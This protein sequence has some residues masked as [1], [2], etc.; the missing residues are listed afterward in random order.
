MATTPE[1]YLAAQDALIISQGECDAC[2]L[3]CAL[4]RAF[5][6]WPPETA[7]EN[8]PA[9]LLLEQLA[10]LTGGNVEGG[11]PYS[12]AVEI[13]ERIVADYEQHIRNSGSAN[14]DQEPIELPAEAEVFVAERGL[15]VWNGDPNLPGAALRFR[16][17]KGE[18]LIR[19][20]ADETSATFQ[21]RWGVAEL[22]DGLWKPYL[23]RVGGE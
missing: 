4:S 2:G 14:V 15:T 7:N 1:Q 5:N 16:A 13:C 9:R 18:R 6:A 8:A 22:S 3:S 17:E 23:K 10:R 11:Q 19:I 20:S 12:E 21:S